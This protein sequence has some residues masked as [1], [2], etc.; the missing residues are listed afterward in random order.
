MK[1]SLLATKSSEV[2][3]LLLAE[4]CNAP[5]AASTEVNIFRVLRPS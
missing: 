4:S 1:V 3:A 5:F 2:A